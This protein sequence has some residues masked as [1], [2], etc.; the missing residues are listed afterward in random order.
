MQT[1]GQVGAP[2]SSLSDG[3]NTVPFR[4]IKTGEMGV[5]DVHLPQYEG[6]YRKGRYSAANQ[7]GVATTAAFATTYTGLVL[8]NPYGSGVNLVVEEI[9]LAE[10]VAQTSA[11]A[12]GL[13]V[14]FSATAVVHT[15]PL[16][17][18]SNLIG[19]GATPIG[20][21]DSSATLPVA[22]TLQKVL[23]SLGT[24]AVT[25]DTVDGS[26]FQLRGDIVLAPGAFL[27]LYTSAASVAASLLASV[28]WEEV[29]V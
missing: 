19:S 29:P 18:A 9:G 4:Q 25:V 27:A 2:S 6:T 8:S 20:K 13:M 12:V 3:T 21:V 5:S 22:P 11:L 28:V 26:N 7:A 1:S 10:L 14:G 23:G 24:G 17:P 15:T 16:V